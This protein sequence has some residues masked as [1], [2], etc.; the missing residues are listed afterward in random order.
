MSWY[1]FLEQWRDLRV[2]ADEFI[3][4]GDGRILVLTRFIGRGRASGIP[5]EREAA[6]VM[7]MRD[8]R[9]VF[10]ANYWDRVQARQAAGLSA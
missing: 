3:D 4:L 2:E 9:I 10:G 1:G 8:G 7:G 6:A 5:F